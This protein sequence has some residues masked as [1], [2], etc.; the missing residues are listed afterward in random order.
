[1]EHNTKPIGYPFSAVVGQDSL[2]LAIL[3][4]R[5]LLVTGVLND[6]S[7]AFGIAKVAIEQVGQLVASAICSPRR[8][9]MS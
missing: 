7:I 3:E 9:H 6:S 4:G 2:K 1:M 5:R 8:D